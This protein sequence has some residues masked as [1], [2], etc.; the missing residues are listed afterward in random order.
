MDQTALELHFRFEEP[1]IV[2]EFAF[3]P[4]EDSMYLPH[5][6]CKNTVSYTGTHDNDTMVGWYQ[7]LKGEEK[8]FVNSYLGVKRKTEVAMAGI[9]ALMQSKSNLVIIPIQDWL[10]KDSASRMNTPSTLG[11]NWLYRIRKDEL[12]DELSEKI[13]NTTKTFRRL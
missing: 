13:H 3:N 7:K 1:F 5:N 6:L 2:L 11:G 10:G 4:Y 12:T 9:R 8:E